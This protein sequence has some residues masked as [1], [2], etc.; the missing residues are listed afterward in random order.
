MSLHNLYA[1]V[2]KNNKRRALGGLLMVSVLLALACVPAFINLASADP[3]GDVAINETNFPDPK[4]RR[5]ITKKFDKDKNGVLSPSERNG[6]GTRF[7]KIRYINNSI[8][9]LKGI[10]FFPQIIELNC[11]KNQISSLDLSRNTN[12]KILKCSNNQLTTL[13]LPSTL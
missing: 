6:K 13:N 8:S 12:L 1:Q 9:N 4:F 3:E 2:T 5:F 11:S 10:E 7:K